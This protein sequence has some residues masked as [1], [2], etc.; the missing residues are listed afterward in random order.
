MIEA[1]DK[2][3]KELPFAQAIAGY[4]YIM[5][6]IA[7]TIKP[8]RNFLDDVKKAKTK[9]LSEVLKEGGEYLDNSVKKFLA[10]RLEEEYF[11]LA[12]G[13]YL[14]RGFQR[15][16][17]RLCQEKELE[18][19]HC[20]RAL[21]FMNYDSDKKEITGVRIPKVIHWCGVFTVMSGFF[22]AYAAL[23]TLWKLKSL[24][25]KISTISEVVAVGGL[26]IILSI[27]LII[28]IVII[29]KPI[30]IYKSCKQVQWKI[31]RNYR[32]SIYQ[33]NHKKSKRLQRVKRWAYYVLVPVI[34]FVLFYWT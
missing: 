24:A 19:I 6:F 9:K 25:G 29:L 7:F 10:G 27:L 17:M 8:I 26:S 28:S 14:N 22:M 18:F 11:R 30:M 34:S 32:V 5:L 13:L 1:L 15:A 31:D 23:G 21:D 3:I 16:M 4:I 2:V 12:T 33:R 20:K